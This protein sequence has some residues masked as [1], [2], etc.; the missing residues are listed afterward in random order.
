MH[1]SHHRPGRYGEPSLTSAA[2]FNHRILRYAVR[3]VTPSTDRET[4]RRILPL[5]AG[6]ALLSGCAERRPPPELEPVFCYQGLAQIVCYAEPDEGR[7]NRLVGIYLRY[8]DSLRR[9]AGL[10]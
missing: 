10:P 4:Q 8:P 3:T 6:M 5:L 2:A 9:A 7:E 1:A